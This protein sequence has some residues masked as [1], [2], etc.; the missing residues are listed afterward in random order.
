M[1]DNVSCVSELGELGATRAFARGVTSRRVGTEGAPRP[2]PE[3]HQLYEVPSA[4]RVMC[5]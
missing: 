4:G 1:A 5:R 3:T 2:E